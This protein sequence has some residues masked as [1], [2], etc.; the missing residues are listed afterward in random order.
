MFM[1][2]K[3]TVVFIT[4]S[5]EEAI[6]LGDRVVI[7]TARPGK[8][9]KIIN[10]T[11]DGLIPNRRNMGYDDVVNLKAFRELRGELWGLIK[12]EIV[13]KHIL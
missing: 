2:E 3:R 8:F 5:V 13:E 6:Y 4:H 1:T 10:V 7:M 12:A 11:D 9:K